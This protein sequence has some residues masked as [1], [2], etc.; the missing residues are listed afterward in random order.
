[1]NFGEI[2]QKI[3]LLLDGRDFADKPSLM[4]SWID[5]VRKEVPVD[6]EIVGDKGLYFL[7]HFGTTIEGGSI[8]YD[9]ETGEGRFYGLPPD[10]ISHE[11]IWYDG[12]KLISAL[13]SQKAS[14]YLL[15]NRVPSAGTPTFYVIRGLEF[16]L[17][18]PPDVAGKE[19]AIDY[20]AMPT[21]ITQD[22]PDTFE[23]EFMRLFPHVH[24]YGASLHGA[25]YLGNDRLIALLSGDYR[26]ALA[27]LRIYNR[28]RW[29]KGTHPRLGELREVEFLHEILYPKIRF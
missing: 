18:P 29:L 3:I 8:K 26:K 1:M 19:I 20:Y 24:Y 11:T 15:A 6:F 14:E 9:P 7:Y 5:T 2:K 16:E 10:Y 17:I 22:T 27:D 25:K 28:M 13:T 12:R 4:P 21:T 23:D